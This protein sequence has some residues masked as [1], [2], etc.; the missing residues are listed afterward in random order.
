VRKQDHKRLAAR[1]QE[2]THRLERPRG[3]DVGDAPVLHGGHVQYQMS[4]RAQGIAC[5]GIG[6]IHTMVRRLGLPQAL[7]EALHL[8]KI[9]A[10]YHESDHVLNIAYNTLNGGTCLE[11]I[12]NLRNDV[13]Y[14]EA[15]DARK[16][17]D[18]TTAGDF[19]RRFHASSLR[20]M[21]EVFN[22]TRLTVWD[23]HAARSPE[24]YERAVIDADGSHVSTDGECKEGMDISHE[25]EWGYH[26]LAIT[27]ANTKEVLYIVNRP[28]NVPS[29]QDAAEYLDKA[30]A[31]LKRRFKQIR[32][33]GDTDFSQTRRLDGW[34]EDGVEFVFGFDA[35]R[36]L[37]EIAENLPD[38]AWSQL[39]RAPK[40]EVKTQ[41]R[42]RPDNVKEQI[43]RERG[44]TN[45]RLQSED[46]AEFAYCP[47]AC[48]KTYRMVVV[49][50]N[51]S[52]EK[53]EDT[54][55]PMVRYFFYITN[56]RREPKEEIVVEANKRCD[57]E[58]IL[59]QLKGGL[60]A[61]HAPSNTLESNWAYM[62][63]ASLAWTLKAWYA[64][65]IP[66]KEQSCRVMRMEYKRFYEN[67][68]HI[69]CQIIRSGRQLIY[70]I[71]CYKDSL[72]TFFPTFDAIRALCVT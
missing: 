15:L 3:L 25:G 5:G 39:E 10:P 40:Y 17:P 64:M 38:S 7:D 57:Q 31:L 54:F 69:P 48:K 35:C 21:M 19:L 24:F 72:R 30:I 4:G 20:D 14:L 50:K 60:N 43:V 32:A 11:D 52:V 36:N 16:I 59:A 44:Y 18:P 68:I 2:I 13:A 55:L 47:T 56:L 37:V 27:L 34:D 9:H 67:F 23:A 8:L 42:T 41:E 63:I 28:G 49:R 33:R 58:N 71:L 65:F 12:E 66:D 22:T 46:I 51:I 29:H 26:P 53:G 45:Y 70:R 1:K 61:L 6:A 62:I